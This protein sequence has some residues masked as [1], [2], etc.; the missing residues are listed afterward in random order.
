MK[1]R[2][3]PEDAQWTIEQASVL[4][5]SYL[6]GFGSLIDIC[7]SYSITKIDAIKFDI[8]GFELKVILHFLEHAKRSLYPGIICME[9]CHTSIGLMNNLMH[10]YGYKVILQTKSNTVY[11]K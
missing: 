8:E 6:D 2:Y 11:E 4:D 7:K 9:T 1:R 10:K 5:V 3:F